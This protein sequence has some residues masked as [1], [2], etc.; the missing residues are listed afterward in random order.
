MAIGLKYR[1]EDLETLVYKQLAHL[2]V[3]GERIKLLE[4]QNE[5]LLKFNHKLVK[6]LSEQTPSIPYKK[7][8][9]TEF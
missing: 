2:D 5:L 3:L 4:Q 7:K 9:K 8:R 1:K 6:E